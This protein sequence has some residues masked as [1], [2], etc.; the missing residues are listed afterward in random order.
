M[1]AADYNFTLEKGTAFII[2]FEYRDDVNIPIDITNWCARIR[3]IEDQ[4]TNPTVRSFVTNT[5]TTEY[6]FTIDP[7]LGKILLKIPAE[8]TA[9]YNFGSAKYD[10]ELQEPNDLYSGGGKKIFRIL[11]GTVSLIAR[12][13]PGDDVFNCNTNVQNDCGTCDV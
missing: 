2:A 13:V 9:Q 10:F 5:R 7:K 1:P 12:N 4:A 11:Q 8:Q 3:W 6:E